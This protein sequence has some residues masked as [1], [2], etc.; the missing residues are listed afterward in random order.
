MKLPKSIS[1]KDTVS[2]FSN[3]YKYKVVIICPVANWYRGN[4]LDNVRDRLVK[5]SLVNNS[6]PWIKIKSQEELDFCHKLYKTIAKLSDYDIRV[7]QPFINFYTNIESNVET[8]ANLNP[9]KIK[10]ISLPNKQ[11]PAL[12]DNTI[13]VKRL[14]FDYKVHIGRTRRDNSNFVTWATDNDKIRLTK[15]AKK[16]LSR[17]SSWGGS[18]FYVRGEKTLTMVKLFLPNE[19]SKIENVIKA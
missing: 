18:Y 16:D 14:N 10:Y 12:A 4:Q 15:R 11:N 9:E 2:L 5:L 17:Q 13:L 3:K 19:I 7:E 6:L 1:I 8:L